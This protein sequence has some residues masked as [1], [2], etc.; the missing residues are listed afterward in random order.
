MSR[1][2]A[3]EKFFLRYGAAHGHSQEPPPGS[4]VEHCWFLGT[5]GG[6]GC[7]LCAFCHF[8]APLRENAA[9]PSSKLI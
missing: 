5:G 4:A 8:L 9:G 7:Q 2:N 1:H 3:P 6:G